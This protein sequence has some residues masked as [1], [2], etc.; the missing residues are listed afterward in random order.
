MNG[1]ESSK[2]KQSVLNA[3][4][5]FLKSNLFA[6]IFTGSLALENYKKSWS[7]IDILI[8]V[9]KL[10]LQTKKKIAQVVKILEKSYELHFGIN[11]ITKQEFRNP[12]LPIISLEGKTLQAILGLKSSPERLFFC[13]DKNLDKIYSPSKS[14]IKNYSIS[15]IA[16]FLLRN[17]RSLARQIPNTLAEYKEIVKKEMRAAFIMTKLA[18]QYFSLYTCASNKE[19]L[20]KA[21]NI[22]TDFNFKVLKNN[23]QLIDKWSQIKKL[24]QL[25]KILKET[26][27]FIEKFSHYV[28][29]KASK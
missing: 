3:F 14:E 4:K 12:I 6:V 9:E 22:F 5:N 11:V 2:I 29:K 1:L 15:N 17:R 23:L 7:D 26:D 19:T 16:M 27:I 28:F 13:K 21:E 8:V 10:N 20:Q 24:Q 18:I 25:D